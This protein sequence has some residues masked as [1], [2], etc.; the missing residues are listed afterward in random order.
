[1]GR[2]IL[3]CDNE[4]ADNELIEPVLLADAVY[5]TLKQK[6][7]LSAE[8]CLCSADEIK[9][10]NKEQRGVDKV[11]D[12][13]SFP[14]AG[15]TA[16]EIVKTKNYPFDF[17]PETRSVFLGSIMICPE[18][19]KEQAEEYGHSFKREINYLAV[20]GLMHIFG[21]D[22]ETETDKVEMREREEAVLKLFDLSREKSERS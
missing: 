22:H 7:N 5:K 14:A 16:G 21:Y 3:N 11:T 6:V 4:I 20:H 18:R 17:D 12:V 15:V 19:A 9:K 1:M 13:L 10:L 8:I 2:L